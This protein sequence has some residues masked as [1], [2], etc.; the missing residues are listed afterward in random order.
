MPPT[1]VRKRLLGRVRARLLDKT[2]KV[3]K[4]RPNHAGKVVTLQRQDGKVRLISQREYH[5]LRGASRGGTY[6]AGRP[7]PGRFT[8]DS[9]RKAAQRLWKGRYRMNQRVGMRLGLP[10]RRAPRVKRGPL[11]TYYA[12]HPT[13]KIHCFLRQGEVNR[14]DWFLIDGFICRQI[15]E[16][17]ALQRLGHLKKPSP[18]YIPTDQDLILH[19]TTI[20]VGKH[21]AKR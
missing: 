15:S 14:Y 8:S 10:S 11:R 4:R 19:V 21:R 3:V 2:P 12:A 17:A 6:T 18:R 5:H 7:N 13:N 1:P 16:R 20:P 9:G